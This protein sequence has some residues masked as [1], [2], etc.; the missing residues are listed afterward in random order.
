MVIRMVLP[1]ALV[2]ITDLLLMFIHNIAIIKLGIFPQRTF[3][4]Q[5]EKLFLFTIYVCNFMFSVRLNFVSQL[6]LY[7]GA[8]LSD[9]HQNYLI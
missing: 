8:Y 9:R 2:Y 1:Y 6:V 4:F 3:S 5:A 7:Y